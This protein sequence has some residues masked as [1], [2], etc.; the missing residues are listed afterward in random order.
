[1]G[2][3]PLTKSEASADLISLSLAHGPRAEEN[4][5]SFDKRTVMVIFWVLYCSF[6]PIPPARWLAPLMMLALAVLLYALNR[7]SERPYRWWSVLMLALTG[8]VFLLV[9]V[10][11]LLR[12]LLSVLLVGGWLMA[13]GFF[14]L[15]QYLRANPSPWATEG[16][17][18]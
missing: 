10:P 7:R 4:V 2:H 11:L 9:N 1:M 14:I 8:L 6:G 5:T 3:Y 12:G 16:A 13:Q 18:A 17:R 15:V